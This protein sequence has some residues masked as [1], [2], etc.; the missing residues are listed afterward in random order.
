[1]KTVPWPHLGSHD[2]DVMPFSM[3]ERDHIHSNKDPGE[4]P[5]C[6]IQVLA[7]IDIHRQ[8]RTV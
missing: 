7:L 6:R 1:M 2:T 8:C 4:R 3:L 5:S